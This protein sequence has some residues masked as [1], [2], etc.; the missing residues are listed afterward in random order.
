MK[1]SS[2]RRLWACLLVVLSF[3]LPGAVYAS[4][5]PDAQIL[6]AADDSPF[7]IG[8]VSAAEMPDQY[9]FRY[10]RALEAGAGWTRWPMY[11]SSIETIP[12]SFNYTAQDE[13][14]IA[15]VEHGMSTNAILMNTPSLYATVGSL[16]VE[17][18]R[19]GQRRLSLN[20]LGRPEI[21]SATSPPDRLYQPVFDD[22]TDIPGPGKQI[23]P[24]NYWARFVYTTVSRYKPG[25]V[26]AQQ[27]GWSQGQGIRHWEM[28][29]EPDFAL[30]WSGSVTDYLRLLK[31]GYLAARH[32]DSQAQILMGGLAYW[33]D[34]GWFPDFLSALDGDPDRQTYGYYFDVSCWHWYSRPSQLYTYT[35]WA[36]GLMEQHG[37]Y[38]KAI[39][40]NETNV[41][42]WDDYPGQGWDTRDYR[43][44]MEEQAA[45]VIQA[46]AWG[47]A[48]NVQ[49]IFTFQL[50]DDYVGPGEAY[51]L[52]RNPNPS[53]WGFP[54][55]GPYG[56]GTPRPSYTAYGVASQYLSEATFLSRDSS[57]G[58][59][60]LQFDLPY[61]HRLRVVWNTTPNPRTAYLPAFASHAT[62]VD[63]TGTT[64]TIYPS[65]G[66]Y[67]LALPVAT[68]NNIPGNPS[69]YMIGG[70]PYLV[71]EDLQEEHIRG[72]VMDN[73]ELGVAG[74]TV[75]AISDNGT[76]IDGTDRSAAY[77]SRIIGHPADSY[78]LNT[79]IS[80]FHDWPARKAIPMPMGGEIVADFYLA[81]KTSAIA[82]GDFELGD[83]GWI[84]SSG[85]SLT[86]TTLS[87][88]K[89]MWLGLDGLGGSGAINQTI[90]IPS[91]TF[92][93]TLSF[94]YN[95]TTNETARGDDWLE[96]S[97]VHGGQTYYLPTTAGK[98][99]LWANTNGWAH[100]WYDLAPFAGIPEIQLVF[101]MHQVDSVNP[102]WV[103]VD[104]IS[105]G[106]A[107]GGASQTYFP[108]IAAP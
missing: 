104:E 70:K 51:G 72:R 64:S 3:W 84:S 106:K 108:S 82:N 18:P 1:S 26:L 73:R 29:N 16:L 81:P 78:D 74:V 52:N 24:D 40:V 76:F 67:V 98:D 39:W 32:A 93:P 11:W 57:G 80:G 48:A 56:A 71:V 62:L 59:E 20:A 37:I 41:P 87:G 5:P 58:I 91:D 13:T 35:N 46:Y 33:N 4:P 77:D 100:C 85:A 89:A 38:G 12:G 63:Q 99:V 107:S 90:S 60:R 23:N 95:L 50:Y 53:P 68:C 6:S 17:P 28:W 105:V 7:G 22:W 75:I 61:D 44:N 45:Y 55:Q 54:Y 9:D 103:Y 8:F 69:D 88:Q 79:Q 96:V 27:Q 30:F 21:S 10:Q 34:Q 92:R 49:R 36:R 101:E 15:D 19:V 97:I 31:V 47:L 14:V 65:G 94:M 83:T 42:V 2:P 25:G 66:Q 102:T 43:A 86:S